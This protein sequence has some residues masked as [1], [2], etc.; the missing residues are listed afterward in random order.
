MQGGATHDHMEILT[1]GKELVSPGVTIGASGPMTKEEFVRICA[2]C[3][4]L[5]E[6]NWK[7][8]TARALGR[9][10][11]TVWCYAAG[12]RAI[13]Q[14]VAE[15]LR[16]LDRLMEQA[17]A[18]LDGKN[19]E[20]RR[21][22]LLAILD[23]R[24][25]IPSSRSVA[26][27]SVGPVRPTIIAAA[28]GQAAQQYRAFLAAFRNPATRRGCRLRVERFFRWS[29]A[30]ELSLDSIDAFDVVFYTEEL[31]QSVSPTSVGVHLSNVRRLFRHLKNAGVIDENPFDDFAPEGGA[32]PGPIAAVEWQAVVDAAEASLIGDDLRQF[33][34]IEGAQPVNK[35]LCEK[36]LAL[37]EARGIKP[38]PA[39]AE[40]FV[41]ALLGGEGTP[42]PDPETQGS[43]V[44]DLPAGMTI[45][46]AIAIVDA[47]L[48]EHDRYVIAIEDGYLVQG[49]AEPPEAVSNV[50]SE[51]KQ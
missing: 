15:E 13:P 10:W 19:P 3:F 39:A 23:E 46:E 1:V 27:T 14:A 38:D 37:G 17:I 26:V 50:P 22:H 4:G 6:A 32:P 44:A 31:R 20:Q 34:L 33:G 18:K 2:R 5:A 43:S 9:Q 11:N 47:K 29:E 7:H 51:E 35:D 49:L 21:R 8:A 28:G 30:R 45:D 12:R 40:N 25:S 36:I 42:G 48:A 16:H 41:A 24:R